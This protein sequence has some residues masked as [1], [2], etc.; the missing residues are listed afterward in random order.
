MRFCDFLTSDVEFR[1]YGEKAASRGGERTLP[2]LSR[3]ATTGR[4]FF[5]SHNDHLKF[6]SLLAKQKERSPSTT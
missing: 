3:A 6:L 5:H 1:G 2:H 4:I